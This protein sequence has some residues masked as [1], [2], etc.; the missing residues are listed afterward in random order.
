MIHRTRL[1]FYLSLMSICSLPGNKIS[2]VLAK[3]KNPWNVL[4]TIYGKSTP[5]FN[6]LSYFGRTYVN[7]TTH[8]CLKRDSAASDCWRLMDCYSLAW[9]WSEP[10]S[11]VMLI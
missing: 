11:T 1:T 6:A 3:R 8:A 4:N 10:D 9:I 2:A 5:A 7:I